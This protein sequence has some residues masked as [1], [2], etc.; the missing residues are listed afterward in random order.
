MLISNYVHGD[1]VVGVHDVENINIMFLLYSLHVHDQLL[2]NN[3]FP[4][5]TSTCPEEYLAFPDCGGRKGEAESI[6]VVMVMMIM[7]VMVIM[8]MMMIMM[9]MMMMVMMMMMIQ[10]SSTRCLHGNSLNHPLTTLDPI[11]W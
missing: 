11:L 3:I 1:D 6:L 10:L 2:S 4:C 5:S 8:I 9:M 7:I